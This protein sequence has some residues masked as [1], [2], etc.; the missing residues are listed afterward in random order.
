MLN[1]RLKH[2][3]MK[4][5]HSHIRCNY[6]Y[7]VAWQEWWKLVRGAKYSCCPFPTRHSGHL[8]HT[9]KHLPTM[10]NFH[11]TP[12]PTLFL[13]LQTSQ[14]FSPSSQTSKQKRRSKNE[15]M[16]C[17]ENAPILYL[18]VCLITSEGKT[19]F[20][21]YIMQHCLATKG[22]ILQTCCTCY[23]ISNP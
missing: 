16:L 12:P 13:W 1:T 14:L 21:R 11:F 20:C 3:K 8:S 7:A 6:G 2:K 9:H 23:T 15:R 5:T 17:W 4:Q 10:L 22:S 18:S 19:A